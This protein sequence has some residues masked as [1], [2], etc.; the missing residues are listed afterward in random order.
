MTESD[1]DI[2][3]DQVDKEFDYLYVRF[4]RTESEIPDLIFHFTNPQGLIGI[5]VSHKIWASNAD[6]LNDSSEPNYALRVLQASFQE[7]E[8]SLR[9]GSAA[10]RALHGFWD[11][12]MNEYKVQGP[13]IYVFCFSEHD[14]LLSQWRSYGGHGAGYALGFS[15]RRL[16]QFIRAGDGQYL[17]KI[18]YDEERQRKEA[19][20]VFGQIVSVIDVAE[21]RF[22]PIDCRTM[23]AEWS[24]FERRVRTAVL[25]EIIRLR[26][27]FK[28]PAFCEEGEWRIAQFVHPRT[29]KPEVEFRLGVDVIRPYVELDFGANKLPIEQITVGP[30]LNTDLARQS[31]DILL[32]RCG[33]P[34]TNVK[35]SAVPFRR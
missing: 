22:G 13:H 26:A 28:A 31:L 18:V 29:N 7:I 2:M 4:R 30:T 35:I 17:V 16:S 11:L 14:D 23:G 32:A 20:S 3:L 6:F 12:A 24:R 8:H 1:I 33:Y 10:E 15:G 27:R 25:S 34:N 9:R 5:A 21:N 19:T